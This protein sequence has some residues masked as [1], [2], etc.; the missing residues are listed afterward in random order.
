MWTEHPWWGVGPAHFDTRFRNYRPEGVQLTPDRTHN[1]YLNTL[2]DWGVVGTALVS[3]AWLL[4]G[5][6]VYE[7]WRSRRLAASDIGGKSTS[8]KYAFVLGGSLGLIAILAHSVVDFNMHIPAN[9]IL[10]ITLMALLSSHLRFATDRY[11]FRAR[12]WIKAAASIVLVAGA[13]YIGTQAVRRATEFV[14]LQRAQRSPSFSPQQVSALKKAIAIEPKNAQTA[15]AL[16]QA[17]QRQSQEGGEYYQGQAGVD[18]RQL[19]KEAMDWFEKAMALNRWDSR[20]YAGYG[21]CLDW[22]DRSAEA[23]AYFTKAEELDPNNYYNLNAIGLHYVHLGDYAAAKPWFERS[24]RLEWR[25]ND[26]AVNYIALLESRLLEGAT[27]DLRGRLNLP[28]Q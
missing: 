21:W 7:T 23:S 14:W 25:G 10:A 11:W 26:I 12:L 1:D 6:G 13:A 4:L 3:A 5:L 20:S 24:A 17:L 18:Y 9:A 16:G 19:A 22:L 27:N 15:Y 2:A 8:N 28:A